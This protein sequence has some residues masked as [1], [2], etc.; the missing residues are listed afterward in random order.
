MRNTWATRGEEKEERQES[1]VASG[2]LRVALQTHVSVPFKEINIPSH[3][4]VKGGLSF[5]KEII[6]DNS[7]TESRWQSCSLGK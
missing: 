5:K 7:E 6:S 4:A 3:Q 2:C 1:K